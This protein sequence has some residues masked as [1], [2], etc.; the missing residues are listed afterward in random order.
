VV[1]PNG[2]AV[3]GATVT[4]KNQNTGV[5]ASTIT[6]GEGLFVVPELIP[7]QYTVTVEP[8]AGFS[9]TAVTDVT[10]GLGQ[11]TNLSIALSVGAPSEI[12]TV[13]S[14]GEELTLNKDESQ[15]AATFDTRKIQD[16]PSNSAAGGLD[17]I[18]L[19]APG[20]IANNS[21]GVNTN[22]TGLSVNGN[23]ARSNN[24]QIDGSDNNDLSVAGPANFVDNQDAVQE[25]QI[26]TN[27]FS[28]QY[29]RNQGAIVNIVTKSGTNDF[30]GTLS[31]FHRDRKNFDSLDN[32]EKASG[33]TDPTQSL[34]NVFGG[35]VGGPV[36]LPHFGE[37]GKTYWSG[38]DRMFFYFAYQGVRN[39]SNTTYRS[40]SLG[41]LSS[42]FPRLTS[43]FPTNSVI[44]D[45]ANFST[46]AIPGAQLNTSISG[47]PISSAFNLAPPTGCPRAIAVGSAAPAGCG[48]YTAFINPATGQAFLTGGPYDVVNI[49]TAAAPQLFQAAQFQRSFSTPFNE[50]DYNLKF[51][52]KATAK[53]NIT[54]RYL[55]QSQ[56]F[57]NQLVGA[58]SANGFQGDVIASSKNFGGNWTRQISN[59]MVNDFRATYQRIAVVFGGGSGNGVG[60][61]PD[62]VQIG[63][64]IA[65]IGLAGVTGVTKGSSIAL[66]TIGPATNLPQGR[67]GKVYQLSDTLN[68]TH[69]N[70]SFIFGG[71]YKHLSEVSPFLPNYNGAFGFSSTARL[72]NNAPSSLSITAGD[73]LIS[74]TEN[75]QYYFVQDDFKLRPNLTLNL[76]IRYEYTGQPINILNQ[77]TTTRESNASTAFFNPSLPLSI[78]TVPKI[79]S[80]KNNFAPRV[81]FAYTPHFWQS[82][83]GEDATVIRGGFSIAYEPAFFNIL[84]NVQNGAPFSAALSLGTSLLPATNPPF[85]I[86]GGVPNGDNIRAA[87]SASGILPLG[88]LNPLFL[89]QTQ[90]APDFHAPYSEQWSLGVQHQFGSNHVAEVRY[91]GTHGVGL[92]Q[93]INGNFFVG[94]MANGIKNWLGTGIDLPAFNQFVPSGVVPQVCV[95][96]PATFDNEAACNG[97]ILR[98]GSITTRANTATSIYHSMQSRYSGRFL[99][100]SLNV[101]ASYTWSKTIDNASEIFG[102]DIASANA[103]NPFCINKCERSLS[104]IDRPH[105]FTMNFIYDVPLMKEQRGVVGHLLG[106][107]QLNGVHVLTSGEPYTPGQFFNGT[108]LGVGNAYLTSGDRPFIGNSSVDPRL[109]GIS[110]ID[111]F[112]FYG[113]ALTNQNGFL[114]LNALNTTGAEVPV[115][116]NDVH[117]IFNG[118]GA[119]K[120]FGTPF[121]T[122]TRN[123][124]R[125]PKLNQLNMSVFKN[126]KI[127]EHVTFQIR[128]EAFNVLN[129]PNPG[130]GVNG[131]GYLP[132]F[133]V[134]DAGNAG[135]AFAENKD[136]EFARRV[137]QVGAKIIF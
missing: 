14:S 96:D 7:G 60:Q 72:I 73:P 87:A 15:I 22:G 50:T 57:I 97:R 58:S 45:I 30:H 111:A 5:V 63:S 82:I 4:A 137:I 124:L 18:A 38:K 42:E 105:A 127:G 93:N 103:Q 29:G 83:L 95:N 46:F 48:A 3:A 64:T 80:D 88:K 9:K 90:V 117:Y 1:D 69:G 120:V 76:G 92:F 109:V 134:E 114:S 27:N 67:I 132:D 123:S 12:V 110:Q 136:I 116:P 24:F 94:P 119:A 47:A 128:A 31:W 68:Y 79:P 77:I 91:V 129:H 74:Y 100:N 135:G 54:V 89:T 101:N 71:E 25:Y 98:Q 113:S 53:D 43:T 84:Q 81:G 62:P 102:F 52:F 130:Y 104:Q 8:T 121:G 75:D 37:G 85:Q 65:N 41:I 20:V 13:T 19:L 108:L 36:Y 99:K 107:W 28:A 106:G 17:T 26:I 115:T 2:Q 131:A 21:G 6:T 122:S 40:N 49:G 39:P 35:T 70:H 112:V 59:S 16:L 33:Q 34:F 32:I 66:H 55:K 44:G 133:F 11:A 86:P 125:G 126:T 51:D 23:R 10:V 118:P 56:N 61:I 78:R